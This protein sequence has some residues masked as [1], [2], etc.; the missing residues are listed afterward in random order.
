MVG[1][2]DRLAELAAHADALNES[3]FFRIALK[4]EWP[5]GQTRKIELPDDDVNT[6][7]DYLHFLYTQQ[8]PEETRLQDLAKLYVFGQKVLDQKYKDAVLVRILYETNDLL[9]DEFFHDYVAARE[10]VT[11][12]YEGTPPGSLGRKLMVDIFYAVT[13]SDWVEDD[14]LIEFR[15]DL[16][17]KFMSS[18]RSRELGNL[19]ISTYQE[20]VKDD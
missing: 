12:I 10:A 2:G 9:K 7:E 20:E 17:F 1:Q 11:T 5:E 8:V 15:D 14:H 4:K 19:D 13:P 3:P 18:D 16:F 6:V